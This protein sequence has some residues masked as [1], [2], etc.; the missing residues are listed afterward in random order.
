M[1]LDGLPSTVVPLPALSPVTFDLISMSQ[2]QVHMWPNFGEISSN[3]YKDIVFTPFL[4]HCLLWPLTS[5]A[6]QHYEPKYTCD[7]KLGEI[8][9]IGLRDMVFRR[10]LG[11]WVI[12]CCELHL[13]PNISVT[14]IGWNSLHWFIRYSIHSLWPWPLTLWPKSNQHMCEPKYIFDQNC[15]KLFSLVC[16]IWWITSTST[17]PNKSVTKIGWN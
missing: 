6:G 11:I 13:W 10:F 16:G 14:K 7:Q 2:A 3:I 15:V 5:K 9:L 4:G 1:E 12:A 17:N 8:P